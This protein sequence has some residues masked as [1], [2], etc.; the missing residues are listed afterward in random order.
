[1]R[2]ENISRALGAIDGRFIEEASAYSFSVGA[3]IIEKESASQMNNGRCGKKIDGRMLLRICLAAAVAA[4][5]LTVTAYAAV[6]IH[7]RRRQEI[8]QN[9]NIDASNTESYVEYAADDGGVTLLSAIND[10]EFQRVYVNISP[11]DMAEIKA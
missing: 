8:R 10:G 3:G 6:S 11:V 7:T 4:A 9:M 5:L 2:Q 1:M